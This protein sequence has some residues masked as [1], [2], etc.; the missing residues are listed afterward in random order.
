MSGPHMVEVTLQ[1]CL[2]CRIDE[3][4]TASE[5][6]KRIMYCH[7]ADMAHTM[8]KVGPVHLAAPCSKHSRAALSAAPFLGEAMGMSP[9]AIA[10][11]NEVLDEKRA[12]AV[13]NAGGGSA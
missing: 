13:A 9:A 10:K 11:I 5:I 3:H 8:F 7:V 4:P 6:E 12:E 1:G 2:F